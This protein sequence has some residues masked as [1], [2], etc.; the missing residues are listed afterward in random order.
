[1]P[2]AASDALDRARKLIQDE[3]SVRWPLLEL[4][5]WFNDGLREIALLKPS[6][7]GVI[8]EM[9]LVA[10]T[11][12]TIPADYFRVLRVT[13]NVRS[14]GVF[15]RA[16]RATSRSRLDAQ[17]PD[18]HDERYVRRIKDVST[19]ALD[20][21]DP[22]VFWVYPGNDGTGRVETV[23]A[24][25]PAGIPAPVANQN[26]LASYTASIALPDIYANALVDYIAYRAMSK[27]AEFAGSMAR[28]TAFY[29]LFKAALEAAP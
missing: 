9:A 29:S 24:R 16:I 26:V 12:Q 5:G 17:A 4:R 20:E 14:L 22:A 13:R 1:M 2:I 28:A 3:D 21:V 27:D 25:I 6:A 19:V 8:I 23:S 7:V 11:K 15:G 18:W 10:G